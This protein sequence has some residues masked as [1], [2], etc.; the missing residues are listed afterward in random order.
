M[1]TVLL[2][3]D[4]THDS[5]VVAA[6]LAEADCDDI[7]I[8]H[9]SSLEQARVLVKGRESGHDVIV[10]ALELA[11]EPGM[12]PLDTV[13]SLG[14][15]AAVVAITDLHDEA[16]AESTLRR[17]AHDVLVKDCLTGDLLR[18]S[19]HYAVSCAG[20]LVDASAPDGFS[21][22]ALFD[23]L[24]D[25][26]VVLD[27]QWSE[28]G[29]VL[30]FALRF[31]NPSGVGLLGLPGRD[32]AVEGVWKQADRMGLTGHLDWLA[33][34]KTG[35]ASASIQTMVG[36]AEG[37]T[38]VRLSA[39]PLGQ[40]VVVTMTD[41][42]PR[43]GPDAM[44]RTA[45]DDAQAAQEA[46]L[47]LLDTL[48]HEARVP[49]TSVVDYAHKI[50]ADQEGPKVAEY[51]RHIA[52]AA[53]GMERMLGD[54][55]DRKRLED[56]A[57]DVPGDLEGRRLMFDL[58]PDLICVVEGGVIR[59]INPA[60][61]SM[62][63][64]SQAE[65]R[66]QVFLSFVTSSSQDLFRSGLADMM[67]DRSRH[68]ATLVRGDGVERE[69]T[70]SAAPFGPN[71]GSGGG[72]YLVLAR[73]TTDLEQAHR[74][75]REREAWLRAI[76]ETMVDALIVI[77][78]R[79]RVE[80]FNPAAERMFGYKAEEILGQSI[81]LLMNKVDAVSHDLY[82]A[83]FLETRISKVIGIGRE[84]WA[85]R[86]DGSDF[87]IELALSV[88]EPDGVPRFVGV[89][90]DITDR[91]EYE[92]RLMD[93]AT[94]EPLTGL[95]NRVLLREK[96]ATAARRAKAAA[97]CFAVLFVDL[98]H[99][100][101]IND[102]LGHVVGDTVIREIGRRVQRHL[103]PENG[104]LVAHLGGDE[105][106]MILGSMRNR[107]D[108]RLRADA[109]L[110]DLA[111]PY[112]FD[113]REVYTTATLGAVLFP[114]DGADIPTLL[115]NVDTA[116][117]HA[118]RGGRG[119]L[120]F[121][122]EDLSESATRRLRIE[123]GLRRALE[124][125]EFDL[126]YQAKVD[127]VTGG[128]VGAEALLRWDGQDVGSVSPAEF[129][130]VAEETGLV[131]PIGEWVLRRACEQ[132]QAWVR[133]GLPPIRMGVN[134]SARQFSDPD[135][136]DKVGIILAETGLEPGML[137]LELTESMLVEQGNQAVSAL[138]RLKSLGITLSIDD[139]GTGYSS[140]SYLKRFPIDY[141]KIDRS[142]VMDLPNNHDD[143]AITRAIVSMAN[144]LRLR[145][146]AE[147][148]ETPEQAEFLKGL[149][150][151]LGQGYYYSKPVTAEAFE[152]LIR[153]LD[154]GHRGRP[155]FPSRVF[156]GGGGMG[157]V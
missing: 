38:R 52:D 58:A 74:A 59:L 131:L 100:K 62:L 118:K 2:I 43:V 152:A 113:G 115:Q 49:L 76:T 30:D 128:V 132:T 39:T 21:F 87:P 73:D 135:L 53:Q 15:G 60:G 50:E 137:D 126:H 65:A 144:A 106:T 68:M 20:F 116:V 156:L 102:T 103:K 149:G 32:L 17:G 122:E 94:L 107:E 25:G 36:G 67:R 124:R 11:G 148:I 9:A 37:R 46:T 97:E 28:A 81:N 92:R 56:L 117:H 51:A 123:T 91:K 157:S 114:E 125:D 95:P 82:L 90:R 121:Y 105:F 24:D 141:L 64:L 147:G 31:V 55:L 150:C 140:L 63:G 54:F 66:G 129:V 19:I 79:G 77:D 80:S 108:V 99:F 88:M 10:F 89:I 12:D 86:A 98:D 155:T 83:R 42:T 142:F 153:G 127:L 33:Q 69:V 101:K 41:L 27:P 96:L 8:D 22:K 134:L 84:L 110:A 109:L 57:Q 130:P 29:E 3:E 154:S 146:V 138:N 112:E 72:S 48:S 104:D 119:G 26:I 136:A 23:G 78:G 111:L 75:A 7:V 151:E 145:L 133:K 61:A 47:R 45:L 4:N 5:E 120:T 139:F 143:M 34:V 40:G 71:G 14:R 1:L 6:L 35:R 70:V 13:L 85:R 44:M 93:V 16:I 18:R